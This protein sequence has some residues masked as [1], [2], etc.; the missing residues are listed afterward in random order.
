MSQGRFRE[1]C[2][3]VLTSSPFMCRLFEIDEDVPLL[4]THFMREPRP[5]PAST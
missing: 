4:I 5:E 1:D 2:F 3:I